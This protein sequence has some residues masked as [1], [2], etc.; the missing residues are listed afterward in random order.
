MAGSLSLRS[1]P[2]EEAS[3]RPTTPPSPPKTFEEIGLSEDFLA[4]LIVKTLLQRG[5][6][7]GH[8]IARVLGL[9]YLVIEETIEYLRREQNVEVRGS[10]GGGAPGYL[11][12]L[13]QRG[14]DR[15]REALLRCSYVGAAPIPLSQLMERAQD[16]SIHKVRVTKE[17][18]HTALGDLVL[19]E[20]ALFALGPALNSG[21]SFFLFGPPGNGKTAV[22][23]RLAA[24]FGEPIF[25]PYAVEVDGEVIMLYDEAQHGRLD[26][27]DDEDLP[28]GAVRYDRRYVRINRPVIITSGELVLEDLDLRFDPLSRV[29]RAPAQLKAM[30]GALVLDDFGRQR[31]S[32]AEILSRWIMPLEYNVDY[33]TMH[34]GFK[35][36]VPF[37]CLLVIASNQDPETLADEAFLRRIQYKIRLGD[38]NR[39]AYEQIFAREAAQRGLPYDPGAV[40]WIFSTVYKTRGIA[41]RGCHPRDLLRLVQD[42]AQYEDRHDAKVDEEALSY[43]C[44]TYF[45]GTHQFQIKT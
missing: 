28:E 1:N 34:T 24:A 27:E 35:F 18:V 21:R 29:Y 19:P 32:P 44:N 6:L 4:D 14:R 30:G 5:S 22:A 2:A 17:R 20:D 31:A 43:A 16:Q 45:A 23:G 10:E 7:R 37:D 3:L 8:E 36:Q 15:A 41:P 25:M 39:E 33:L 40:E 13:S 42:L 9:S 26:P 12:G 38:P 11:L